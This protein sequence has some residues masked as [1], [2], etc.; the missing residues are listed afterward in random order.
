ML[1]AQ[2]EQYSQFTELKSVLVAKTATYSANVKEGNSTQ[3]NKN[4]PKLGLFCLK[5]VGT[6]SPSSKIILGKISQ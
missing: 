2:I 5:K 3:T 4:N 1:T 6:R